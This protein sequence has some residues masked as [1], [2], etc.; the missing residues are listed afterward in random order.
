MNPGW[1]ALVLVLI[2]IMN[3]N[4]V[5]AEERMDLT[6]ELTMDEWPIE[7]EI[8]GNELDLSSDENKKDEIQQPLQQWETDQI[9][10]DEE[11]EEDDIDDDDQVEEED[12]TMDIVENEEQVSVMDENNSEYYYNNEKEEI[13][14]TILSKEDYPFDSTSRLQQQE[15]RILA[16]LDQSILDTLEK[17]IDMVKYD[18]PVR[19]IPLQ[20]ATSPLSS[21]TTTTTITS[22]SWFTFCILGLMLCLMVIAVRKFKQRQDHRLPVKIEQKKIHGYTIQ[23]NLFYFLFF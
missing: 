22:Y 1:V 23:L 16:E 7:E 3:T 8:D 5:L 12:E 15:E 13:D 21:T 18:R 19:Y 10:N 6:D 17:A 14:K 2:A 9:E 4:Y 11:E 20:N